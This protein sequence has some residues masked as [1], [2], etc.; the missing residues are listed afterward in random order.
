[1]SEKEEEASGE[2]V[3]IRIMS[4]PGFGRSGLVS[5]IDNVLKRTYK[6][7]VSYGNEI[8]Q[9]I[10]EG[11]DGFDREEMMRLLPDRIGGVRIT[12]VNVYDKIHRY[13]SSE[14]VPA[15]K[16]LEV[17]EQ[18][19]EFL[20]RSLKKIALGL[21]KT[22]NSMAQEATLALKH[23]LGRDYEEYIKKPVYATVPKYD[24]GPD[25]KGP[26]T[27]L[28]ADEMPRYDNAALEFVAPALFAKGLTTY[29]HLMEAAKGCEA[30]GLVLNADG[31]RSLAR[32]LF[33]NEKEA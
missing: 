24:H 17:A 33:R 15:E 21:G 18:Q 9:N 26:V 25:G 31:L 30:K 19:V 10:V 23:S 16:L 22:A 27:L 3:E 20:R 12:S 13:S 6:L 7:P 29:D 28:N 32:D 2:I 14:T 8:T 11:I 1:M 4:R 5:A